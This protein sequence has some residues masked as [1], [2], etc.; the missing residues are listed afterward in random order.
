MSDVKV[1]ASLGDD[2]RAAKLGSYFRDFLGDWVAKCIVGM[3]SGYSD[4]VARELVMA[5][6]E[7]AAA[8]LISCSDA[9]KDEPDEDT[10]ERS[11]R[12]AREV[13]EVLQRE[14]LS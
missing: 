13:Y 12:A 14:V 5:L 11:K 4:K 6:L 10:A 3:L 8:V 7:Y 1:I 9:A 2:D